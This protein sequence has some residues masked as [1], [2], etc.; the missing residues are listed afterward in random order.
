[1]LYYAIESAE[2]GHD[3]SHGGRFFIYLSNWGYLLWVAYLLSAAVAVTVHFVRT[4]CCSHIIYFPRA[5]A[6]ETLL[7]SD[8]DM[9]CCKRNSDKTNCCDKLTWLLFVIGAEGAVIICILFWA[10][11]YSESFALDRI[12]LHLHLVNA[13]VALVDLWISGV[14]VYLLHV[15]SLPPLLSVFRH[16]SHPGIHQAALHTQ[17]IYSQESLYSYT[18]LCFNS[19]CVPTLL[20]RNS[21]CV[22]L[23]LAKT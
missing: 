14:P 21:S 4:Y 11:E 12:S 2:H 1:L 17:Y 8:S 7:D 23:Y 15:I 22:N 19:L 5:H 18:A 3:A 13:V 10:T 16:H 6:A 20:S 9:R